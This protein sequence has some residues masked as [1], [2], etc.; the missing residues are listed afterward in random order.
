MI[1]IGS[2]TGGRDQNLHL[3]SGGQTFRD[4]ATGVRYEVHNYN[5]YTRIILLEENLALGEDGE[6]YCPGDINGG[7]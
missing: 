5:L 1:R 4:P 3:G 6:D 7:R 2:A